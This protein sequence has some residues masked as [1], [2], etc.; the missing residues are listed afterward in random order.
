MKQ[1]NANFITSA[2][3]LSQ[4]PDFPFPE[5]PLLGRSNVGESSF[6]NTLANNKKIAKTSNTPGKTRL[7]NFFNFSDK[8]IIADLPGYGYAKVSREAQAKWQRYLEEYLLNR[9]QIKSLI[10]FIDARHDIQKNDY[11]MREWVEAHDLP[12][13][14]I[15]TKIDY[16]PRSDIQKVISKVKREFQG[17]VLPFSSI[18]RYYCEQTIEHIIKL[19][20]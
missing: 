1:L 3:K 17:E 5:F 10:Q 18:D 11:Q 12:I 4:C 7:I 16:I 8:F 9:Q 14:T 6:I 19:S 13:F 20:G 2:E 15:I